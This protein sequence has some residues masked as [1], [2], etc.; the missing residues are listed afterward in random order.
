MSQTSDNS[1]SSP[2]IR[3]QS[4]EKIKKSNIPNYFPTYRVK[5]E[6]YPIPI[7]IVVIF[8][9]ILAYITYVE[10]GIQIDG[11]YISEEEYG[12]TA[13]LLNGIIFT[14]IAIVSSF[15]IIFL[16]KKRGINVLKYVF[17]ISFGFLCF[18]LTL[19]YAEILLFLGFYNVEYTKVN[20]LLYI[21]LYYIFLACISFFTLFML[22]KYFTA[23]SYHFRNFLV[24]YIGL[25]TG[26]LLGVIMPLWTTLA[27][28]IG[29]SLWDIYAVK[30]KRGPIRRMI[31]YI[32]EEY[33]DGEMAREEAEEKIQE[34]ELEYDTSQ[35][36][37]G[38][39]D[40]T[41]Y[42][43]LTSTALI[44]TENLIVMILTAIAIIIGTGI[45]ITGLKRNKIL[46]GL[47]ISIFLGILTMLI[48]WN[49]FQFFLP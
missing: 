26:A 36:E 20:F 10:A 43:M 32:S 47:P 15:T 4:Q 24:L 33:S 48:S 34:G 42:S 16:I 44:Q 13:G 12:P 23:E 19:F 1:N 11:G 6:L 46:P 8:A 22:Y 28:L 45:T 7:I 38:I 31:D 25:T 2:S 17:G 21:I 30:A 37:I 49:L 5:R 3:E 41:F 27:I 18:F 40:L 35:L 29:I 9:G 14:A 39:G